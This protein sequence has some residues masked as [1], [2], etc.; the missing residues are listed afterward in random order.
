MEYVT[1]NN[2]ESQQSEESGEKTP[3]EDNGGDP[4]KFLKKLSDIT[5]QL[6]GEYIVSQL[7][8][9]CIVSQLQGECSFSQL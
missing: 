8:G 2:V 4:V 7:Q 6:Q 3:A 5:S 9:E 1:Y